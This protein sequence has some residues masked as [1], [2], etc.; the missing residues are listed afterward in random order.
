MNNAWTRREF[1][2]AGASFTIASADRQSLFGASNEAKESGSM[3]E[4]IR[5]GII[6]L[7]G[8]YSEIT[9][10]SKLL[11]SIHIT[12]L[13][14]PTAAVL[15]KAI[16]SPVFASATSW[17]DYR[18]MLAHEKLDVVAVCGENGTRAAI[19]KACAERGLP[20]I[21]EKP[22]ALTLSD[23]ADVKRAL[24][25]NRIPLT[26]LLTMRFESQYPAMRAIV[27]AGEIGEVVSMDAQKSYQLGNRPEWMKSRKTFGGTIPYIGIHLIDL[28]RWISG[29]EMVESAAFHSTVSAPDLREM[30]NNT[31][32]IFKLD[33]R[34]TASLRMDY[35]RPATA[36]THGDDRIRIVG[37]KGIVE[38]QEATGLTLIT[39]SHPSTRIKDLPRVKPLFIDFLESIYLKTPHLISSED[40]FRIS[41]IVL[42]ARA[43]ADSGHVVRL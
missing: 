26:M 4:R 36:P 20:I 41:E 39:D 29:R 3:P 34:G 11:P 42:K 21:A 37:T 19:V 23:L 38:Y 35:L 5:V 16:R 33:N 17:T 27:R 14:D 2:A 8:H 18:S 9:N 22:L 10:A 7:E 6:G 40:V 13:A 43:A 31:A 12:A 28:M 1:L 32:V 24:H 25:R 30:E 15:E